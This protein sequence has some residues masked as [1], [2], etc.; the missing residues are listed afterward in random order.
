M[1]EREKPVQAIQCHSTGGIRTQYDM[2]CWKLQYLMILSQR[3]RI[4][5]LLEKTTILLCHEL[6]DR[7]SIWIGSPNC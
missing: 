5:R 4:L 2:Q 1:F 6:L 3:R 7:W